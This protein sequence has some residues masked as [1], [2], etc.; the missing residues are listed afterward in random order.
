M[1]TPQSAQATFVAAHVDLAGA[2]GPL[3]GGQGK[4]RIASGELRAPHAGLVLW[5]VIENVSVEKGL[6]ARELTPSEDG[7]FVAYSYAVRGGGGGLFPIDEAGHFVA[8]LTA[9]FVPPAFMPDVGR[10]EIISTSVP[11][12][13]PVGTRAVLRRAQ[14]FSAAQLE[15]R[16]V[17]VPGEGSGPIWFVERGQ[18]RVLASPTCGRLRFG[19]GWQRL[20]Q[21]FTE[22]DDAALVADG[23]P[24][25]LAEAAEGKLVYS[26]PAPEAFVVEQGQ[27]RLIDNPAPIAERFGERW[28]IKL[29]HLRPDELGLIPDGSPVSMLFGEGAPF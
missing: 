6:E 20:V 22:P 16:L 8:E 25:A 10:V 1:S 7:Q 9:A 11:P 18:K 26:W 21:V 17:R 15:G 24:L 13:A 2:R 4:A 19:D 14:S 12:D 29:I 27:K 5:R 3:L 23:P 28:R